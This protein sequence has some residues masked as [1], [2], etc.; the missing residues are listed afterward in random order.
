[1]SE[2]VP[3]TSP[4][5]WM[6]FATAFG[7]FLATF[8]LEDVAAVGA[9]L[10]LA[11]G[12]ISWP[13]AFLACFLGIWMGDAGL[14]ALA[15]WAG[16]GWFERSSLKK[17]SRKVAESERWFDERGTVILV[18]S[19][20]IPGARLPTY[21]AAGFLRLP[22]P[23]FLLVTGIASC[24]WT[25][26]VLS[27]AQTFGNQLSIWLGQ[28]KHGGFILCGI[29]VALFVVLQ[30]A[31]RKMRSVEVRHIRARIARWT[32][33]E[34]WPAW[35][36]YP[37][38]ALYC[39]WLAIRYRGLTLPTAANPGIFSGGIVGESKHQMLK[40]LFLTSP[41]FTAEARF[42]AVGRAGERMRQLEP[43]LLQPFILKPD[44]GQRGVG[45]KLIRTH[46]QAEEYLRQTDAP[47]VAQRYA[48]GPH[49]AG[50]FY[51]RFPNETHGR[52]FA[53]TEKIFPKI[54]GDGRSTIA[55]LIELDPRASIIAEK[56]LARFA[57]RHD[58]VLAL[59]EE[60]K[61]VEAGNHA[62]G[63]IFRDG[64]R[65]W[66]TELEARIDEISR[67]LDGFFIGRYDIRFT[68]EDDLCAGRNFLIIELNGAASEATSIYDARNSL[69]SAYRTLFRQWGTVFAIGSANRLR[70]VTP[71]KVAEV[72]RAWRDY[73]KL[74][75]SYPSAD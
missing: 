63:C 48:P 38:V 8:I 29:A 37:P 57:A 56:Y 11:T 17:F 2:A 23:R 1:M 36:F 39:L 74:S 67:K 70:G 25:L 9:G 33:W 46:Q 66:T 43:M 72:W 60:L 40:Q 13:A 3:L 15:R 52:I 31:R 53:I 4:A 22:L 20:M 54:I 34:F 5:E 73:T 50:I 75:A 71:M 68:S 64:M 26:I 10:L 7:F 69:W 24:V 65:L 59:G 12:Q 41:E 42:I 6:P 49:E 32:Q 44:M 51:Y 19:R 47:L 27:L 28:Y 61:L 16:R 30:L 35:L 55:E 14:Y 21:L 45:I 58:E 62:Q 18:F